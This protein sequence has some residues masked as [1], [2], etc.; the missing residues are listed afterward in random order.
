MGFDLTPV[1]KKAGDLTIG[2]F[3]WSLMLDKGIGLPLRC[4]KGFRPGQF[5]YSGRCLYANDGARITQEEACEMA[6]IAEWLAD[7]QD[8]LRACY[9]KVPQ[10]Q[11]A[12]MEKNNTGLY[13]IPAAPE[14]CAKLREF[15][16]WARKSRGFRVD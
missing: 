5:V 12:E 10:D 8:V 4:G 13:N 15:A 3:S 6:M 2:A 9:D 11:R 14:W 1:N 16:K 7:Y